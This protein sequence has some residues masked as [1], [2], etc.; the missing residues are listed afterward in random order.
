VCE[1]S[2]SRKT[3]PGSSEGTL[4]FGLDNGVHLT[5]F[6]TQRVSRK[7]QWEVQA[8]SVKAQQAIQTAASEAQEGVKNAQEQI[9]QVLERV[10]HSVREA[11]FSTLHMWVRELRTAASQGDWHRA[12]LFAEECPA[13]AERLRHA[14]G[15]EDSERQGLREGADNI[16]LVQAYIRS[17]RLNTQETGLAPNH[18]KSVEAI[19]ALLERLGGRLHHEPTKGEI[20]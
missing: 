12:L 1:G 5:L 2:R 10:R 7:A 3:G 18:A 6:E 8:A 9:R 16:R 19:A 4:F 13:V 14:A 20:P 11:D 17:N 15:L